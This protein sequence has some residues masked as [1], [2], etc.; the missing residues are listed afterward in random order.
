MNKLA[1]FA[2]AAFALTACDVPEPV[3]KGAFVPLAQVY[4][5]NADKPFECVG[6]K[7]SSDSCEGLGRSS[8]RGH[9]VTSTTLFALDEGLPTTIKVVTRH[10]VKDGRACGIIG[11]AKVTI[12]SDATPEAEAAVTNMFTV[13]MTEMTRD[14]CVG[15]YRS[16]E[17]YYVETTTLSGEPMPDMTET[18][19]SRFFATQKKLRNMQL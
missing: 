18:G 4:A 8:I 15:Y 7:A 12:E 3:T 14:L 19:I 9:T 13:L 16:G 5:E 2:F 1:A 10:R 17:G 11:Q 6:Y